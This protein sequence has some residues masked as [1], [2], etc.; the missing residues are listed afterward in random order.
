[1]EN[2]K[3]IWNLN[4][5]LKEQ[6]EEEIITHVQELKK[7]IILKKN[8]L[9]DATPTLILEIIK[10]NEELEIELSN[11]FSYYSL[12]TYANIHDEEANAKLDYY[13][14]I[15][16]EIDN[17]TMFFE[18][19]LIK[20]DDDKAQE[21]L[22]AP[23]LREYKK[24]I[25]DLIKLKPHTKTEEIE[26]I[27]NIKNITGRDAFSNIYDLITASF[28][29]ELFDEK[30]L[31]QEEITAKYSDKDPTVREAAYN[32]VLS[33]YKENSTTLHEIYKNIALGWSGE[34]I[35]IRNYKNAIHPRNHANDLTEEVVQNMLE[36]I[37]ENKHI[38]Q[39][40]FKLKQKFLE[41]K[42]QPHKYSRYHIYAPYNVEREYTYAD[43]KKLV[44]ET[45]REF[46]E[47][48]YQY[49]KKIFDEKHIHSHPEKG[50]RSGAFCHA[51]NNKMTP[52]IL[53]NHTNK[54]RDIF[55]MM[56]E[57]GHAIHDIYTYKNPNTLHHPVLPLAETASIFGE[58]IL[59]KK[60]IETTQNEDEKAALLMHALDHYYASI[61]RQA[62]FVI[63]EEIAHKK[64]TEGV[65]KK[66]LDDIYYELLKEQFGDMD[67]P[68]LFKCEWNY[69]P[70]IHHTPFYC[71][72]YSWGNLL[73]LALYAEYEKN[74]EFKE[75]IK[76]ILKAG[77]TKDTL[78][79]LKEAGVNAEQKKFW[80][81]G[82][83]IIQE[84]LDEYK[85]IIE[86][87]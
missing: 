32:S 15:A 43:S 80:E 71:Y 59:T 44:L 70:H 8:K 40:Y 61:L 37:R 84:E 21:Y 50:K 69:I 49:A 11:I 60:L 52:Y 29:F 76:N 14:Q 53:L 26:K 79:I 19:W 86:K 72:A 36:V 85:K 30:K 7:E 1:M 64:I 5:L 3:E 77:G 16:T 12:R 45:Y 23:E 42:G 27:L 82:F 41:K 73:V 63:F 9:D 65:T 10:L 39:E 17:E 47:E 46:D 58:T 68:E 34:K 35:K 83:K 78:D 28:K 38:F 33:V 24:H 75:K 57:L 67:V 54:L 62:Y 18:L 87:L 13:T 4:D 55:T 51:P 74:P 81:A 48:F 6:S 31:T 22:N 20:L 56:H 25:K 2:E 66:E